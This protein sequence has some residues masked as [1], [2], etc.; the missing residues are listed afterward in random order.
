MTNEI[1]EQYRENKL[2]SDKLMARLEEVG[3]QNTY[4]PL[5]VARLYKP[6]CEGAYYLT[7]YTKESGIITVYFLGKAAKYDDW[8]NSSV[9]ALEYYRCELHDLPL[10]RDIT[11]DEK[12]F[13]DLSKE[14]RVHS[15]KA[16]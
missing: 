11:F 5:V 7:D 8:I 1:K 2:L 9:H 14:K 12:H 10:A 4:N 6:C 15:H 13:A 16:L 3:K